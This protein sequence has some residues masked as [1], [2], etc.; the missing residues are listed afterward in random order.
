[1]ADVVET[2]GGGGDVG[3]ERGR[4][5]APFRVA[6]PEQLF[7]IGEALDERV[8]TQLS[9]PGAQREMIAAFGTII[10]STQRSS[11]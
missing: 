1:M 10:I 11:S 6:H 8:K 2:H 7:V 5:D 9:P 4:G 3:F